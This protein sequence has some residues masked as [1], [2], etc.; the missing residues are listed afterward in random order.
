MRNKL[1]FILLLSLLFIVSCTKKNT[2]KTYKVSFYNDTEL[3]SSQDVEE[4][5]SA[6]APNVTKEGHTFTGWD[7]SFNN[8]TSDLDVHA[9]FEA[10]YYEITFYSEGKKLTT[11]YAQYGT[12]CIMDEVP[13][14]KGYDFK[15]W[16]Q[17]ISCIKSDM[18]V[19]A[20]FE[21]KEFLVTF[22]DPFDEVIDI[23]KVKYGE[24]ATAP[25]PPT[26]EGYA[27]VEWDN[28]FTGVTNNM[29]IKA[30]YRST[31]CSITYH[32][33]DSIYNDGPKTYNEGDEI[34]LP[35][36]NLTGYDFHGWVLDPMSRTIYDKIDS[37]FKGDLNLYAILVETQVHNPLVLPETEYHFTGITKVVNGDIVVYQPVMPS[38]APTSSKLEY[39]WSTS[40]TTIASVSMYSSLS[41]RGTGYCVLTGTLKTNPS[42]FINCVIHCTSEGI[43]YSSVEEANTI[44]LV[45]VT[46]LDHNDEIVCVRKVLK[47][48]N[49]ILPNMPDR[50]G[51]AF[52]GWD[53]D[54][55]GIKV[56]TTFRP[57]YVAGKTNPF[58]GKSFSILGDSISTF[59]P[60]IPAGFASFYPYPTADVNDV[61]MTWWMQ[62][63][64]RIG[65]NL[66]VNNS[67]SGTCVADQSSNATK[68]IGRIKYNKLG[69]M[70]ADVLLV[71][72]GAND[73]A[74]GIDVNT[75]SSGYRQMINNIKKVCP[76]QQIVLMTLPTSSFYKDH[77]KLVAFNNVIRSYADEFDLMLIDVEPVNLDGHKV[78][79][80]HPDFSGMKLV[81]DQIVKE[82][83]K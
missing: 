66:F 12:A 27:F 9:L 3:V 43:E 47:G 34:E 79:S 25:T 10:D 21:L 8:V 60:Y 50:D 64:N 44:D 56:D 15:G 5:K 69:E 53:H 41:I 72:M 68:N 82:I 54:N 42:I 48:G 22:T 20:V 70:Y 63:L 57:I 1:L 17:D 62:V 52:N 45:N 49:V 18:S 83:I 46:F 65:G 31:K 11:K 7:K 26:F 80:G 75:F 51:Y 37:S 59:S 2:I 29:T 16:D 55:F 19:N 33:A 28:D 6:V 77:D 4:G 14:K 74:G 39:D 40:D 30:V 71:F 73:C 24:D 81:A 23:V 35:V 13:S 76:D 32:V 78:D 61:N 67:Y 58:N 38:N 36:L